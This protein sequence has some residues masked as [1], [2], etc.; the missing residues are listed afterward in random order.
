MSVSNLETKMVDYQ[1]KTSQESAET[2]TKVGEVNQS[3][4]KAFRDIR[5]AQSNMETLIDQLSERLA[6]VERDVTALQKNTNQINT[7]SNDSYSNLTEQF[8][9]LEQASKI[10]RQQDLEAIQK[11]ID[12]LSSNVNGVKTD[13]ERSK[14]TV[15]NLEK[16][17]SSLSEEN[18]EMYRRILQELGAKVPDEK[19]QAATPSGETPEDSGNVHEVKSGESLSKI[20]AKYNVSVTAM[21]QLNNLKNTSD[22]RTGQKLKIP[23]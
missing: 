11:S 12:A 19:K 15:K 21:Q 16:Q 1:E 23:K 4:N 17:F 13:N 22:I 14:Q 2:V 7:F 8:S 10:Q 5:Y 3:I 9:N 18:R 20:A 6:K